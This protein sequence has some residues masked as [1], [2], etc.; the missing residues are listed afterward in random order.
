[1]PR[2]IDYAATA[3]RTAIVDKFGRKNELAALDVNAGERT[4]T[5]RDGEQTAEETRDELM[6]AIRDANSYEELWEK[7]RR[8]AES[9]SANER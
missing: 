4:I 6:A 9:R 8:G 1:M 3:V 7:W 5:V 2:D